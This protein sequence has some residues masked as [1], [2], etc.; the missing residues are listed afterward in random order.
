MVVRGEHIGPARAGLVVGG[1][2]EVR[3]ADPGVH[4]GVHPVFRRHA[5]LGEFVFGVPLDHRVVL[6]TVVDIR[7]HLGGQGR[8][9]SEFDAAVPDGIPVHIGEHRRQ[10]DIGERPEQVHEGAGVPAHRFHRGGERARRQGVHQ[11]GDEGLGFGEGLVPARRRIRSRPELG[12][13]EIDDI[14]GIAQVER[15]RPAEAVGDRPRPAD[16]PI[17]E[18]LRDQVERAAR[19]ERHPVVHRR[20][21]RG[22]RDLEP[23]DETPEGRAQVEFRRRRDVLAEV[24]VDQ[25]GRAEGA[26]EGEPQRV[27]GVRLDDQGRAG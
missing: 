15:R 18:G 6:P 2:S 21:Q 20:G 27:V 26:A 24:V 23:R 22:V 25:R 4:P 16:F 10:P 11:P 7:L 1:D 5:H 13:R 19:H 9:E 14:A 8:L 12:V 3:R 17:R